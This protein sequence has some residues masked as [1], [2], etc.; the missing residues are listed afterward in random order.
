[1]KA[2]NHFKPRKSGFFALLF[3]LLGLGGCEA[4]EAV[5]EFGIQEVMY[6]SPYA[7]YSVKGTVTDENGSPIKDLEVRLYGVT[8]Y[9]G[10]EYSIPNHLEPVK[11]DQQGTYYL[12]MSS[13]SYYDKLQI[14][15]KDIDGAANG[16]EFASD[17]LR[18]GT[19]TF[20]KDKDDKNMWFVGNAD[21]SMP[22]I[23]L[24]KQP[25]E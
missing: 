25:A 5:E 23:K 13:G 7:H 24:K 21:I 12:K 15:V 14:N 20:L 1:M 16:G 17:S 11:T 19:L 10:K 18:S 8:T 22:D 2:R 3:A 9:E 4:G 6:G